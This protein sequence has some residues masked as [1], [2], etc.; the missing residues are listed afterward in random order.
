MELYSCKSIGLHL[1]VLFTLVVTFFVCSAVLDRPKLDKLSSAA[2]HDAPRLDRAVRS[3]S[4]AES[5]DDEDDDDDEGFTVTRNDDNDAPAEAS[6][7]LSVSSFLLNCVIVM[8][9]FENRV[10]LS[11]M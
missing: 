4:D 5:S 9:Y 7:D 11:W 6:A 1:F 10:I 3:Q 8:H 2:M